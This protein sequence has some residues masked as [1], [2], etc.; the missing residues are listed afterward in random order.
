MR[1][2]SA[3]REKLVT[4]PCQQHC[5]LADMAEQHCSIFEFVLR[6]TKGKIRTAGFGTIRHALLSNHAGETTA[7]L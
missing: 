3:N 6:K 2:V 1:A 5:F 7:G 4:N